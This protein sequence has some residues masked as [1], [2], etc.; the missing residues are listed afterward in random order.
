[1]S[2]VKATIAVT[3]PNR[4]HLSQKIKLAVRFGW[5]LSLCVLA[6]LACSN[7]LPLSKADQ[8]ERIIEKIE[9]FK[10]ETRR[11]PRSLTEIGVPETE[12]GP[13]YYKQVSESRYQVWFGTTLGESVTYDSETRRWQ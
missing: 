13:V 8:G 3:F 7:V 12:E 10:S 11:L 6:Q 2:H 4:N 9:S 5:L 1:M